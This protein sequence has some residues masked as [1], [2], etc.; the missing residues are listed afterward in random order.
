MTVM[1]WSEFAKSMDAHHD[2]QE[3]LDQFMGTLALSY[4]HL[5]FHLKLCFLCFAIF[6]EDHAIPL[7]RLILSWIAEGYI[8]RVD[9]MSLEDVA[10]SYL[11]DLVDRNLVIIAKK[12]S[13]G[14]VKACSVHDMLRDLCIKKFKEDESFRVLHLYKWVHDNNSSNL[15]CWSRHHSIQTLCVHS[16]CSCGANFHE[17][18][19]AP[20]IRI[21]LHCGSRLSLYRF[22]RLLDLNDVTF[23]GFPT[24]AL[25]LVHLKY[26]ALR[27]K[28]VGRHRLLIYSLWNLETFILRHGGETDLILGRGIWKMAKLR[29]LYVYPSFAIEMPCDCFPN[30][31]LLDDMQTMTTLKFSF[32]IQ[33]VLA[34]TP[35]IR[36]L[37]IYLNEKDSLSLLDFAGLNHLETLE[38]NWFSTLY[39]KVP[40]GIP[41]HKTF[42]PNVKKLT[43]TTG[44]LEW[45][46]MT[47]IGL[48]PNLEVLK[49]RYNCFSGPV[50]ETCD[51]GFCN[52]KFLELCNLDFKQWISSDSD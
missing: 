35:N 45:K 2:D 19:C 16:H 25:Q 43:L 23:H 41:N 30:S 40:V 24:L 11:M 26:L 13:N 33:E 7:K 32:L 6:P 8:E 50:W 31:L 52:L 49:V 37:G 10:M 17:H 39:S 47:I 48:L 21:P 5:A 22:L 20:Y 12:W 9:N 4:E 15:Q 46:D 44:C 42:P 34:R 38:I 1:S 28:R 36:K 18:S 27:V 14:E 29:H 3:V 51:G